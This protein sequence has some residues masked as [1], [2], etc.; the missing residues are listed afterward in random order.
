MS[1]TSTNAISPKG[2][3]TKSQ[4]AASLGVAAAAAA[5]RTGE[6]TAESYASMLLEIARKH[7]DLKAFITI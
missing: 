5:I 4:T 6:I 7:S 1:T 2:S 3:P